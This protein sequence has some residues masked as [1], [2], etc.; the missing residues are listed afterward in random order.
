MTLNPANRKTDQSL[1]NSRTGTDAAAH[2]TLDT[3][4]LISLTRTALVGTIGFL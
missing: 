1:S 2:A 3:E 4:Q